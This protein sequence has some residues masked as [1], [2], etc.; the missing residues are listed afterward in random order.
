MKPKEGDVGTSIY[1]HL[2]RSP[3]DKLDFDCVSEV[4]GMGS[5]VGLSP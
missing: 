3:G 2:V 1:S 5:V 4:Q